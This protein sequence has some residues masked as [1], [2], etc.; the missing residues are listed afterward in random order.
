[1]KK[2]KIWKYRKSGLYEID[3]MH[4]RE[5]ENYLESVFLRAG[6]KARVTQ[7]NNDYGADLV[8]TKGDIKIVVQAKRWNSK[9]GVKAIQEI[10]A[11]KGYYKA[12]EAWVMTNNFYTKQAVELA[13]SNDV[14]LYDRNNITKQIKRIGDSHGAS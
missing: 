9:V 2:Y 3:R 4:G 7:Y 5:F 14:K 1:M 13:Q 11:A 10:V 12:T 6:Y 8:A